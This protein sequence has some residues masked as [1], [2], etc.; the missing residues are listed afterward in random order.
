M[1]IRKK[2]TRKQKQQCEKQWVVSQVKLKHQA[3]SP[4]ACPKR[5]NLADTS[6]G[7]SSAVLPSA[8]KTPAGC[9]PQLAGAYCPPLCACFQQIHMLS[10]LNPYLLPSRRIEKQQV[11]YYRQYSHCI[12]RIK[13]VSWGPQSVRHK[14]MFTHRYIHSLSQKR[15][16]SSAYRTYNKAHKVKPWFSSAQRTN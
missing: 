6:P 13:T 4:T 5:E 11:S 9:K 10:W 8:R 1:K 3:S 15:A 7:R 14:W 2:E 12:F 16:S